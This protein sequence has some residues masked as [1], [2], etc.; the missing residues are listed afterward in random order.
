MISFYTK[1]ELQISHKDNLITLENLPTSFVK[2]NV[3]IDLKRGANKVYFY[4][5]QGCIR[6]IDIPELNIQD[7][8]CVSVAVQNLSISK[9]KKNAS[10]P[11][12]S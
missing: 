1:R 8:R 7:S 5:P 9:R 6:P 2:V 11:I 12:V 3:P 4:A 10:I